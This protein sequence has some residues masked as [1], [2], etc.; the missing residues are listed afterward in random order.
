MENNKFDK[1]EILLNFYIDFR[2]ENENLKLEI[3]ALKN[4]YDLK[5]I[6]LSEKTGKT[7]KISNEIEDRIISN[8]SKIKKYECMIEANN[9]IMRKL[10]NAIK[11]LTKVEKEVIE[12]KYFH[13]PILNRKEIST[14]MSLTTAA[15]DNVK[16]RAIRKMTK[17]I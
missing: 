9:L 14:K 11:K 13:T 10:K 16:R 6:E 8:D 2:I 12:L 15:I 1:T 4:S 5:S 3:E 7:N 17:F